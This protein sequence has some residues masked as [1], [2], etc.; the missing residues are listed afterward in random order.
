MQSVGLLLGSWLCRKLHHPHFVTL[1]LRERHRWHDAPIRVASRVTASAKRRRNI[2]SICAVVLRRERYRWRLI[3][4]ERLVYSVRV[5]LGV[6]SA[7]VVVAVGAVACVATPS[8]AVRNAVGNAF[9]RFS[10]RRRM[11]RQARPLK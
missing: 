5:V 7:D 9:P 4:A 10:A 1:I 11:P 3:S 8:K 2:A 6:D